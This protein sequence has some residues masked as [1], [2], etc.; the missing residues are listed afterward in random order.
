M[1]TSMNV[2]VLHLTKST[3]DWASFSTVIPRGLL[4]V[5]IM[6]TGETRTKIGDGSKT[7]AQLPYVTVPTMTG[8][9]TGTA[10]AA[11][12]VP[13]PAAGDQ[14]KFLSGAGTWVQPTAVQYRV[15]AVDRNQT[16]GATDKFRL[17]ASS[18]GGTTWTPVETDTSGVVNIDLG[19]FAA[20]ASGLDEAGKIKSILLPSYV[21]D[22]IE[23][24]YK[25]ADGKFYKEAAYTTEIPGEVGKIYVDLSTNHSYRWS[26]TAFV[27]ISNPLDAA[28]IFSLMQVDTTDGD[29]NAPTSNAA[30]QHGLVP[31]P[32]VGDGTKFLRG[33]AT[34]Q[35]ALTPS[36]ELILNV[37]AS[38]PT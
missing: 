23:G 38:F 4:C 18:D 19:I 37:V 20:S 30:G 28:T 17:Q 34:W 5:E 15:V 14:N 10:G 13:A 21:D 36:D 32:A 27:D 7:F 8:A 35:T 24:Y 31:A 12:L 16:T 9:A 33:D 22:I 1:S 26:G 3:S 2:Q 29:F 25:T 6:T 11:G